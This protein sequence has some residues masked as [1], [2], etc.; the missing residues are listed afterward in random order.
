M[1]RQYREIIS[2]QPPEWRHYRPPR[3]HRARSRP[4]TIRQTT[5]RRRRRTRRR[6]LRKVPQEPAALHGLPGAVPP[7][8]PVAPRL[9][10]ARPQ[11]LPLPAQPRAALPAGLRR[12]RGPG[13]GAH[14]AGRLHGQDGPP[15][16]HDGQDAGAEADAADE[17]AGRG[18]LAGRVGVAGW[19]ACAVA[20]ACG[21][22]R[23]GA[24]A[25]RRRHV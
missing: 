4:F 22:Y 17:R 16:A 13:A 15:A 12:V 19:A 2:D 8:R 24:G 7:R 18:E 21:V 20:V 1:N 5:G 11:L 23:A 9:R 3:G 6:L 14:P 25:S 10:R